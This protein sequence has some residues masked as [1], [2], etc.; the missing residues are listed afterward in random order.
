MRLREPREFREAPIRP[1]LPT[2]IRDETLELYGFIFPF[3]PARDDL[4]TIRAR[5]HCD[6]AGRAAR[7]PRRCVDI[8]ISYARYSGADRN[9]Q[10][11]VR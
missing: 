5:S 9:H 7:D 4:R 8:L 1:A 11:G 3:S 2:T 10:K 6:Q